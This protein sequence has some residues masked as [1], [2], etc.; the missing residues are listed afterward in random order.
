MWTSLGLNQGAPDYESAIRLAISLGGDS[1]TIACMTGGIAAA[2]YGIP[3]WLEER[4]MEVYL[5][6]DMVEIIN[7]FNA[8]CAKR[9]PSIAKIERMSK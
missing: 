2:Y 8:E 4:V 6:L 3:E 5:P 1:D 7:R 9:N